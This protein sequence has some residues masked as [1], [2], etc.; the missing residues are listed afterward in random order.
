MQDHVGDQNP[1]Y[2]FKA[3][4]HVA[5]PDYITQGVTF[6]PSDV[7]HLPEFSF[8]DRV[9]RLFPI[10]TK[11]A[12]VMS[13]MCFYGRLYS[14]AAIERELVKAADA[15]GVAD[16]LDQFRTVFRPVEKQA[17]IPE[18]LYALAYDD[19][20]GPRYFY[21]INGETELLESARK[22]TK[23]A[24]QSRIP[25]SFVRSAARAMCKRATELGQAPER[26]LPSEVVSLGEDRIVDFALAKSAVALRKEFAG[27]SDEAFGLYE[28][29]IDSAKEAHARG[30]DLADFVEVVSILDTAHSVKYSHLIVDPYQVFF[31]GHK[32]EDV[33]KFANQVVFVGDVAIPTE[34][35][36]GTPVSLVEDW[37]DGET[38]GAIKRARDLATRAPAEAT[39]TLSAIG[40]D[41]ERTLLRLL[42]QTAA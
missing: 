5:L 34:V 14:D 39:Q 22:L 13:A 8:A 15:H 40:P 32:V 24:T 35:M 11:E 16:L 1:T 26:I 41:N 36:A 38:A 37:F 28:A 42:L 33:I 4:E 19:G 25:L 27:I 18:A 31:S 9:N 23:A 3:A 2:L 12:A 20:N 30:E 10:H 6:A 21:P 7:E 17:G 29:T